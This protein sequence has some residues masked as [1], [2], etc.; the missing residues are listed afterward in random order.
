ME[1][2]VLEVAGSKKNKS[3][4]R[5]LKRKERKQMEIK[6]IELT[7]KKAQEWFETVTQEKQRKF[8]QLHSLKIAQAIQR[9]EW[10]LNNDLFMFDKDGVL[11]N[12]QHRAAA[13]A[14]AGKTVSVN[15]AYGC[16]ESEARIVDQGIMTRNNTDILHYNGIKNASNISAIIGTILR[17]I[18]G[19]R[20][21]P[22]PDQ[23][24][25]FANKHYEKLQ[26]SVKFVIN[27]CKDSRVE[28]EP[29]LLAAVWFVASEVDLDAANSFAQA[30]AQ[31]TPRERGDAAWMVIKRFKESKERLVGKMSRQVKI[32]ILIKA[33]NYWRKD[34]KPPFLRWSPGQGEEFPQ[35]K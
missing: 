11:I 27:K 7:P 1:N 35:I 23:C 18:D 31:N 17:D 9:G 32:A 26:Y 19:G 33:F 13:I 4:L 8:R 29:T 3:G 5:S 2:A 30:I 20:F 24:L 34:K 25:D 22:T 6:Q 28:V 21:T 15:V 14:K 10:V 12:G 16:S